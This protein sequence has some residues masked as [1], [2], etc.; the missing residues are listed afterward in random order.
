MHID[1]ELNLKRGTER[2]QAN[3]Y[4]HDHIIHICFMESLQVGLRSI[5]VLNPS[6]SPFVHT[7][8]HLRPQGVDAP[9]PSTSLA[10]YSGA[11]MHAI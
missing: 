6:T 3:K 7:D 11:S 1:L 10:T 2:I 4:R 9:G 5:S 8:W